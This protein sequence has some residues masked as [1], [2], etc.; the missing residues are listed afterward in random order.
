MLSLPA[1]AGMLAGCTGPLSTLAPAGPAAGSIASLW[2]VML[3]GATALFALVMGLFALVMLRPDW[4]RRISPARWIV[5]GGL[6]LP[7]IVLTPLLVFA[8]LTGERLLPR[9]AADP[10]RIEAEARQWEWTFRYPDGG[11]AETPGVLHL[12]A[13]TP[14]DV[15]V[16]SADVIHA[17]WIPRLAGKIDAV[18]GHA[19][20]LSIEADR[21][22]T[23]QGLCNEFC[24]L[25]HTGM[26]FDVIVHPAAEFPAALAAAAAGKV[27]P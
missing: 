10:M 4:A 8:L 1:M 17:F 3:A 2:W 14:V 24:G 9:L 25:G 23:Y 21:P 7:A 19:N 27:Q 15:V 18:P 26:R 11:G 22:G 6:V 16:T 5:L 20:V 12:P 13:G